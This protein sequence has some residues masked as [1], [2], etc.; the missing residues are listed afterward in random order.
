MA[1]GDITTPYDY[2]AAIR[3]LKEFLKSDKLVF[4]ARIP[5]IVKSYIGDQ[6]GHVELISNVYEFAKNLCFK[7]LEKNFEPLFRGEHFYI[8]GT[9]FT[10]EVYHWLDER[11]FKVKKILYLHGHIA[12][13]CLCF[14]DAEQC[15][16]FKLTWM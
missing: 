16:E 3:Y 2:W 9:G 13:C 14:V 12:T 10:S 6:F 11:G 1:C 5:S 15:V 7:D 4:S 8:Y